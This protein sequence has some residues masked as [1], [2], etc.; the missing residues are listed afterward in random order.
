VNPTTAGTATKGLLIILGL[1][2]TTPVLALAWPGTLELAYGLERPEDPMA[3]ALLQHR[4][5]LQLAL[6]AALVWSAFRPAVRV[7]VAVTAICTKSVF[8]L[9]LATLPGTAWRG[10]ASGVVFDLVAIALLAAMV[11]TRAR[12]ARRAVALSRREGNGAGGRV[13]RC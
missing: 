4:G 11:L 8:L 13:A 3:L 10:A 12:T 5:V 7:P 1:V 9:L 2:T 6:G